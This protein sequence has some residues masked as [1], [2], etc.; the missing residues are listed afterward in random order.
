MLIQIVLN[1]LVFELSLRREHQKKI[2]GEECVEGFKQRGSTEKEKGYLCVCVCVNVEGHFAVI[3]KIYFEC[4][5]R[6]NVH[7]NTAHVVQHYVGASLQVQTFKRVETVFKHL[8][9]VDKLIKVLENQSMLS[10]IDWD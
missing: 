10:T 9:I 1:H 8:S 6:K 7:G 4:I 2:K 3:R 5:K